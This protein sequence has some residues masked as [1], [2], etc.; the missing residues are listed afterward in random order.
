M[1]KFIVIFLFGMMLACYGA[2]AHAQDT[3]AVYGIT[4]PDKL[5]KVK[6]RYAGDTDSVI[7]HI[8]DAHANL[9]A[10]QNIAN[11]IEFL[12]RKDNVTVV[13]LEG[14]AES[15][16]LH[17]YARYPF[18]DAVKATAMDFVKEGYFTGSEYAQITSATDIELYGV[19][20][21]KL[22]KTN[23]KAY[24]QVL[25]LQDNGL[26]EFTA[27][28]DAVLAIEKQ[29]DNE[30]LKAFLTT[31]ENYEDKMTDF[32]DFS[33]AVIAKAGELKI[34][35]FPYTD[36]K[37]YAEYIEKKNAIDL[38]K[39]DAEKEKLISI[40]EKRSGELN[41]NPIYT[42]LQKALS[43]ENRLYSVNEVE[44]MLILL[45]RDF[46]IPEDEYKNLLENTE[47]ERRFQLFNVGNLIEQ[48]D[49]L[50]YA[51]LYRLAK[52]DDQKKLLDIRRMVK[53]I[54]KMT[55]LEALKHDVT[56]F[57]Q[58]RNTI[59]MTGWYTFIERQAAKH[60]LKVQLEKELVDYGQLFDAISTYYVTAIERDTVLADNIVALL[61]QK[62]VPMADL[63]AGGYHTEGITER[64]REL[65]QS[66]V[67][68]M[69]R[70]TTGAE[71]IPLKKRLTGELFGK[72]MLKE[73]EK[74][75]V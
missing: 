12:A 74:E 21:E 32:V 15:V 72:N 69:P 48:A 35:L 31:V 59:D 39:L 29:L 9:E 13:G 64:L 34:D 26:R 68:I 8:Q 55:Q 28:D 23:Y 30:E 5:G 40:F 45:A 10:Q 53:I 51:I 75:G 17:E 2:V 25:A 49:E 56:Y 50:S 41:E 60:S 73:L 36:L 11:I 37:Q 54:L 43:G 52:T 19:E 46:S 44:N 14:S 4:V 22:M 38:E 7:I 57:Q 18:P 62:N 33:T 58:H 47:I 27:L 70:I 24:L 42:R 65:K 61:K 20:N 67:V 71:E 6:E 66:Y 1:K 16:D 3:K 63:V